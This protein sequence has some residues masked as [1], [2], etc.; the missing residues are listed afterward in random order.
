MKVVLFANNLLACRALKLLKNTPD[1]ELFLVIHPA[2]RRTHGDELLAEAD[3]P[4][5][6]IVEGD[7]LNEAETIARISA[8]APDIGV[9]I[10]FDYI[11]R[12]KLLA[13]FPDGVVNLHPSLLPYNR[14]QYPNVWSI[15]ERTPAGVTLHYIDEGID[16]GDIIAQREIAIEPIDTGKTLYRKLE[17]TGLELFREYWPKIATGKSS[18]TKQ[19]LVGTYHRKS[20][21]EKFDRIDLEGRYT[22]RELIDLI[23]ARTFPPYSGAYFEVDG[24]RV[25]L[26]MDLYYGD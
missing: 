5:S 9:S 16:T 26:R 14:G 8:F 17:E 20:D 15:I 21:V 12:A 22:A 1:L 18:R 19:P 24:R 6:R 23:R 13:L 7:R 3:L 4:P 25:Y 11:L 2:S 10:L